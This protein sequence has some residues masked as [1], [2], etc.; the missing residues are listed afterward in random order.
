MLRHMATLATE[1]AVREQQKAAIS[2]EL[3]DMQMVIDRHFAELPVIDHAVETVRIEASLPTFTL[4]K[5][6][7][8]FLY[9]DPAV[10]ER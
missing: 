1:D 3:C 6:L 9:P 2:R 10:P 4:L 8:P 5:R 7:Y